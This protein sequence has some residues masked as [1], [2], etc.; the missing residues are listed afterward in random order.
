MGDKWD[1][2]IFSSAHLQFGQWINSEG[3][4][5]DQR[6]SWKS[7]KGTGIPSSPHQSC[8]RGNV[9]VQLGQQ[10]PLQLRFAS[11]WSQASGTG[12]EFKCE[13]PESKITSSLWAE[14]HLCSHLKPSYGKIM[15]GVQEKLWRGG[16]T[17]LFHR[18]SLCLEAIE[19]E[20]HLLWPTLGLLEENN[21]KKC[22]QSCQGTQSGTLGFQEYT[23]MTKN[24][25]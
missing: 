24:I 6:G 20:P 15:Q 9:G 10:T 8:S 1:N 7:Q 14:P 23:D 21:G 18:P 11:S 25:L 5:G 2:E 13:Q 17:T 3:S 12:Q 22:Y 4:A 16:V 19:A